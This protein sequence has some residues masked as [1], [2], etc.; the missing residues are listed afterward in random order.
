MI[1]V[2]YYVF[3]FDHPNLDIN[4]IFWILKVK[5]GYAF[6]YITFYYKYQIITNTYIKSERHD[7]YK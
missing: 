6:E 5:N 2:V 1:Q 3:N 7:I 4:I